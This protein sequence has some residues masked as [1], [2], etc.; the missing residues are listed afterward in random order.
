MFLHPFSQG[1]L[2]ASHITDRFD[3]KV[4]SNALPASL[5]PKIISIT[6]HPFRLSAFKPV[7]HTAAFAPE[8]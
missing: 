2:N 1:H 6:P 4:D 5:L 3:F 7:T 8:L